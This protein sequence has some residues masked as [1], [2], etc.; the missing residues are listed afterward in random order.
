MTQLFLFLFAPFTAGVATPAVA[1]ATAVTA[2]SAE[3]FLFEL[4]HV[5]DLAF[6]IERN[7][8]QL[9]VEV[10]NHS[11]NANLFNGSRHYVAVADV[12]LKGVAFFAMLAE[13]AFFVEKHVFLHGV[14]HLL[15]ALAVAFGRGE[16]ETEC[17]AWLEALQTFLKTW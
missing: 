13:I 11:L 4:A 5:E 2:A 9:M 7:A 3:V 12:K 8:R 1:A 17:V 15:V 10:D 16:V 6:E 14:D